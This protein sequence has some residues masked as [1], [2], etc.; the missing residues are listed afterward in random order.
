MKIV[1]DL[2]GLECERDEEVNVHPVGGTLGQHTDNGVGLSVHLY[3][4]SND[5]GIGTETGL[6]QVI[7][8][9]GFV[10]LAD[11]ALFGQKVAPQQE[12]MSHHGKKLGGAFLSGDALR[13]SGGR[14]VNIFASPRGQLLKGCVLPLSI[15]LSA[16]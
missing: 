9:D 6:P 3:L 2:V 13:S 15:P 5:A 1:V 14:E 8:E 4:P 11:L 12:P 16:S 10:V 7:G